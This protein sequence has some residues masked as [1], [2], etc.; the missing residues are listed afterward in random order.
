MAQTSRALK[1]YIL[2]EFSDRCVYSRDGALAKSAAPLFFLRE[3]HS[4]QARLTPARRRGPL[5]R[6][7]ESS[8]TR[9]FTMSVPP[10]PGSARLYAFRKAAA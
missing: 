10:R 9:E 7:L 1:P 2:L 8:V 5:T 6:A 3:A 4:P